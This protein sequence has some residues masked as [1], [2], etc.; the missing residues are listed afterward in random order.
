MFKAESSQP[1]AAEEGKEKLLA[2][3]EEYK[4]LQQEDFMKM[5]SEEQKAKLA[6]MQDILAEMNSLKVALARGEQVGTVEVRSEPLENAEPEEPATVVE[7]DPTPEEIATQRAADGEQRQ[8]ELNQAA[9]LAERIKNGGEGMPAAEAGTDV[10]GESST[11]MSAGYQEVKRVVQDYIKNAAFEGTEGRLQDL[12][13]LLE[14]KN[15]GT[16]E[17][18]GLAQ[19]VFDGMSHMNRRDADAKTNMILKMPD[20]PFLQKLKELENAR[21]MSAEYAPIE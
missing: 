11:E 3:N 2:L 10:G 17:Q 16:E 21:L 8:E 18:E 7:G 19:E 13:T 12:V 6:R 5:S 20:S 15:L 14:S 4:R 9:D 1:P